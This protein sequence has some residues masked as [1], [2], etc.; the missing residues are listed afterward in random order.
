MVGAGWFLATL[1]GSRDELPH[2]V[3]RVAAWLV[4]IGIV[5]L[6]LAFPYGRLPGRPDRWFAGAM[7]VLVLVLYVPTALLLETY[8]L[9]S[10]PPSCQTDCP[11]NA[12][13][14]VSAEPAF[15]REIVRPLREVLSLALFA[16]VTVWLGVRIHRATRVMRRT[17]RPVLAVAI[18]AEVRDDGEGFDVDTAAT[19]AGFVNMRDRLAAVGGALEAVSRP[20]HGTRVIVTVPLG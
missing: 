13:M 6:M 4:E 20:G 14:I 3:G 18:A 11:G 16:A 2:S 7:A 9:P 15:V 17:L 10:H 5:Y 12:F 19:G 8:P 1:A